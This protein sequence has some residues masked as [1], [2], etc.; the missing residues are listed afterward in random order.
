MKRINYHYSFED[1]E[2]GTVYVCKKQN[3][4]RAIFRYVNGYLVVVSPYFADEKIIRGSLDSCR[5]GI[6][7]LQKQVSSKRAD[8]LIDKDFVIRTDVFDFSISACRKSDFYVEY[9]PLF[10][11]RE[12][13][14]QLKSEGL[15]ADLYRY[16]IIFSCPEDYD[17]SDAGKQRW[18]EDIIVKAIQN[19]AKI[20]LPYRLQQMSQQSGL[21]VE[22]DSVGHA[23]TRWGACRADRTILKG[24]MSR[25]GAVIDLGDFSAE[26]HRPHKIMLSAYCALLPPHLMNFI[27]LHELTHTRH[28]DHSASFHS[29]LNRLTIAILGLTEAECEKQMKSYSTN[30]FS[31]ASK[32][33]E[34]A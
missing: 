9:K 30:I 33:N 8:V 16:S 1:E 10:F 7:D 32:K 11:D 29:T 19:F 25:A 4:K 26:E 20:Y 15:I 17:F 31:F 14:G 28:P 22:R 21:K 23:Q 18:L 13:E 3:A 12:H 2:F 6:R 27:I 34:P 5:K 24:T